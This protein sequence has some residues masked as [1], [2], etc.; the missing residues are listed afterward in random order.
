MRL[1]RLAGEACGHEA[2]QGG[3]D[4]RFGVRGP[5]LVVP[6]QPSAPTQ[7]GGWVGRAVGPLDQWHGSGAA[8]RPPPR[9]V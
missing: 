5:A 6:G 7:P 1:D 9:T 3:L 8:A 2:D 4:H